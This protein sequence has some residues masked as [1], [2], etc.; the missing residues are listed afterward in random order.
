MIINY[1][2]NFDALF[3]INGFG[4]FWETSENLKNLKFNENFLE[5]KNETVNFWGGKVFYGKILSQK[6]GHIFRRGLRF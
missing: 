3:I 6:L 5:S 1:Y 2:R 4:N